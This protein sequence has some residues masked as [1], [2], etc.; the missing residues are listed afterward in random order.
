MIGMWVAEKEFVGSWKVGVQQQKIKVSGKNSSINRSLA[1][2]IVSGKSL[3]NEPK[4]TFRICND[5]KWVQ[6]IYDEKQ[7]IKWAA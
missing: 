4:R 2:W 6:T 7:S 3:E 1:E 5:K